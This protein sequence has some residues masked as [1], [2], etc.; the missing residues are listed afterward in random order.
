MKPGFFFF[1]LE[2]HRFLLRKK[3]EKKKEMGFTI[4]GE[5]NKENKKREKGRSTRCNKSAKIQG[6]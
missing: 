1:F 6:F 4:L 2:I 3:R 5:T